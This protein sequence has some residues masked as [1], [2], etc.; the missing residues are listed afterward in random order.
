MGVQTSARLTA[1]TV[2]L[3]ARGSARRSSQRASLSVP[4]GSPAALTAPSRWR[5]S[6]LPQTRR[7]SLDSARPPSR[8]ASPARPELRLCSRLL[9]H[10]ER[11]R[12]ALGATA[13]AISTPFLARSA[14]RLLASK[15]HSHPIARIAAPRSGRRS[16]SPPAGDLRP[17]CMLHDGDARDRDSRHES[18]GPAAEDPGCQQVGCRRADGVGGAGRGSCLRF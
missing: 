10:S 7:P 3:E 9:L 17:A 14:P 11:R 1:V 15:P 8:A 16:P 12:R 4:A 2:Q 18:D 5:W 6:V 13:P